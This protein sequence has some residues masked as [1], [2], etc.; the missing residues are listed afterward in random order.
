MPARRVN[1]RKIREILRLSSESR[2]SQR[3]IANC[4]GISKT[5]VS[6][7]LVRAQRIG[8]D[9][10]SASEL[11]DEELE[12]RLY[13][14]VAQVPVSERPAVDWSEVHTELKKKAVTLQLLWEE[15][16]QKEPRGYGYSRYCELY[17][18]WRGRSGLSMRQVHRAGE[19]LFVDYCG[20]TVP[21]VDGLS[22]EV[23]EAQIIVAV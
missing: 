5:T 17:S 19:K 1:V 6:E 4:C 8:L 7:Y 9:W 23:R 13:P 14:P 21:V 15:Y 11:S 2:L 12:R 10:S 22:G 16:R 3:Q 18:E 20:A